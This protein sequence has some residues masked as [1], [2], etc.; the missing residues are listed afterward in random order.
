[1]RNTINSGPDPETGSQPY[2]S[3]AAIL[4]TFVGGLAAAGALARA[5]EKEPQAQTTLDFVLLAGATFKTA[6]TLTHDRVASFVRQ[7]FVEGEAG[8]E[9]ERPAGDGPRRAIGELVTCTRCVGTWAA[10]GLA[11]TQ[12]IAPRFGRLLTWTLG[13]AAASD[14]LQAAFVS[15]TDRANAAEVAGEP[16]PV[17]ERRGA[18]ASR[19]DHCSEHRERR[20]S[21]E[22]GIQCGFRP[23]ESLVAQWSLDLA[24]FW[25]Y[26]RCRFRKR[27]TRFE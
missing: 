14:F 20:T 10:A 8:S 15:L 27:R 6:R 24:S 9:H 26:V 5:L 3:Y 22:I 16:P 13:A 7:P 21:R 1:M 23:F 2:S 11:S 18:P 4:G 12:I 25:L 17:R 19:T